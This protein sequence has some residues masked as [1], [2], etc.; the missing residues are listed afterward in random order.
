MIMQQST[1]Q[2]QPW[3]ATVLTL[4]P[5]MFPGPLGHSVIGKALAEQ[6]WQLDC[7]NIR[8]F[9]TDHYQSVDDTPYGG[10]AGMVMRAD[11]VAAALQGATQRHGASARRIY[12][13]PRGRVFDQ[14]LAKELVAAPSVL[15][16][17]GRY[18]GLDQRVIDAENLEEVS[19]GDF[20]L[21]GGE[22][23]AM[24]LLEAC[25]RLL[26]GVL[27]NAETVL[28]ESF[29]LGLLE[30]PHYTRPAMWGERAVPEILLSGHHA[31][32]HA[33]RRAEAE[34]ITRAR[35]PDLWHVYQQQ[36][37]VMRTKE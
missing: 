11:I 5:E 31:N 35:R 26:P 23:A 27:G 17:C 22:L 19:M 28:E 9:T 15:M 24:A 30:Y 18:E 34:R 1:Q 7:V 8:D 14:A 25:I 6:R 21:A 3:H 16:L 20:V 4:F 32:I 37:T 10:G 36:T 33:W 29:E 12:L 2:Q 13:S